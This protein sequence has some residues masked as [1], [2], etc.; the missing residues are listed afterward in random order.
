MTDTETA[1][2]QQ[3]REREQ[4][5]TPGPWH[6]AGLGE[7]HSDHE[8]GVYVIPDDGEPESVVADSCT[9]ADAEFIVAARNAMPELLDLLARQQAE[10][11]SLKAESVQALARHYGCGEHVSFSDA[12]RWLAERVEIS[13]L[14]QAKVETH[15][16]KAGTALE[17]VDDRLAEL[18]AEIDR[19]RGERDKFKLAYEHIAERGEEAWN[20][21]Q[22]NSRGRFG[23]NIWHV[24]LDDALAAESAESS[25]SALREV[26]RAEIAWMD[27]RRNAPGITT[28]GMIQERLRALLASPTPEDH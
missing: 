22:R 21:C 20:Y 13:R 9:D 5:A 19:L 4:Q 6:N 24:V 1:Q 8:N 23:R 27:E 3:I 10:I 26:L 7:V 11:D 18:Q 15:K 28:L 16:S 2:V 17:A 25:L 12:W 14:V